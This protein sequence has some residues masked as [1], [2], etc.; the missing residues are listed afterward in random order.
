MHAAGRICACSLIRLVGST[1]RAY[2]AIVAERLAYWF[3][4]PRARMQVRFSAAEAR[5][6][7]GIAAFVLPHFLFVFSSSHGLCS[8]RVIVSLLVYKSE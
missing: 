8:F 5:G 7:M 1:R 6:H 2:W 3:V 4:S